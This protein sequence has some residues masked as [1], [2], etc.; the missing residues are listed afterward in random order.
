MIAVDTN[1]LVYSHRSDSP[2]H[3]QAKEL[4]ETLRAG[5]ASWAIPWP[6]LHEFLSIVTHPRIFKT[7]TPLTVAFA[8]VDAWLSAGNLQFIGESEGYLQKLRELTA[9]ARLRGPRIHDARV[10]AIC[11]HHGVRE[12]WS[13]DRDFSAFPQLTARNPLVRK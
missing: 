13:C 11:L 1:I 9:G 7:P 6:C 8:S 12:L 5:P 10:A 2:F 3:P 4:I